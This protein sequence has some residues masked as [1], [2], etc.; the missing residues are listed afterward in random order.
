MMLGSLASA[1]IYDLIT[2]SDISI[3]LLKNILDNP[4]TD[5]YGKLYDDRIAISHTKIY[6]G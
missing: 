5:Y 3:L 1:G 6:G 4:Y 2:K